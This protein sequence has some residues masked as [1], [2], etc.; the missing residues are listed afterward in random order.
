VRERSVA[1]R[2]RGPE[3]PTRRQT[4][5]KEVEM[6]GDE[7]MVV[8]METSDP[9][10]LAVVKSVLESAGIPFFAKG[11]FL[12]DLF[13]LGQMGGVNPITGPVEVQV[14]AE[15]ADRARSLLINL[16]HKGFGDD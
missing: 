3:H 6:A 12:Q 2:D 11:E 13:G 7:E 1:L 5:G 9:G 14:P 10:L 4:F 8:V 15:E 16:K